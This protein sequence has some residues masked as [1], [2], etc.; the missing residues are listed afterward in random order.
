MSTSRGRSRSTVMRRTRSADSRSMIFQTALSP[1][2]SRRLGEGVGRE[3][4]RVA[5]AV[6]VAGHG[7]PR[8][9]VPPGGGDLVDDGSRQG[10]HVTQQQH[11]GVDVGLVDD[12]QTGLQGRRAIEMAG[13][14][15]GLVG[16]FWRRVLIDGDQLGSSRL[17]PARPPGGWPGGPRPPPDPASRLRRRPPSGRAPWTTRA[18]GAAW[19]VPSVATIPRRA[20]RRRR[21]PCVEATTSKPPRRLVG[22]AGGIDRLDAEHRCG[23]RTGEIGPVREIEVEV[24]ELGVVEDVLDE[25]IGARR[26]P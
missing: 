23:G 13:A 9:S 3:H 4:E 12:G 15:C 8:R 18:G 7:G 6:A 11:E 24:L 2:S 19:V 5:D 17:P 22:L 26:G 16:S 1:W 10:G 25:L 20:R 21:H 14:G